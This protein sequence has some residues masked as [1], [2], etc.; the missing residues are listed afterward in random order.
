[1]AQVTGKLTKWLWELGGQHED[2]LGVHIRKGPF[3]SLAGW[4]PGGA[5]G[6]LA[7]VLAVVGRGHCMGTWRPLGDRG[8]RCMHDSTLLAETL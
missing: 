5:V 4:G 1:M 6:G 2:L 3:P 8:K 7:W